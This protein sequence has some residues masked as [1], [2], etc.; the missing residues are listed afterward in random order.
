MDTLTVDLNKTSLDEND[1]KTIIHVIY[2]AW[3]NTLKQCNAFKLELS[4]E[5]VLVAWHPTRCWGWCVPEDEK[6]EYNHFL[7]MKGS[8]KFLVFFQ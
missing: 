6:K 3:S 4:K 2:M 8:I 1:P 5:L 7:L